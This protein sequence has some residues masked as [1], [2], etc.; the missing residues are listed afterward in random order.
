[1]PLFAVGLNHNSAPLDV[2][3]RMVF[4]GDTL[5][6]S[7][8]DL[9]EQLGV[10]EAVIV[11]TCNRT[12]LYTTLNAVP[13]PQPV[14]EWLCRT[15]GVS[16]DWLMPYLY[17]HQGSHAL[18]HLLRV[19]AGLDSMIL[20]EPQILGQTKAAYAEAAR[21]G[22]LGQV[23]SRA[24]QHA[25]AVAKQIRT[26]TA[27]GANP[28]SVAFAAVSLARQIFGELSQSDALLIGAGE[29]IE[30]TARHLRQAGIR[31]IT[32]ANRTLERAQ[33]LAL[34]LGA[35]AITLSEIPQA[36]EYS[37]IVIA[38]TASPLP[39]IGKGS[40]ERALKARKRKPVFMVDLAVPRDIE[41]EVGDLNDVYLYTVDDLREVIADN[42]RSRQAAAEQ[43][44]EIIHTQVNQFL[45]WVRS[46]E[47][48]DSI[49]ALR[50]RAAGQRDEILARA[51]R[52]LRAGAP[53]EEVLE[54]LANTLTNTLLH[55][56]TAGLREVAASGD[57]RRLSL[58]R[59]LLDLSDEEETTP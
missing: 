15:R 4:S 39:I 32:V 25:F 14:I 36:L 58:A 49:Q 3:E 46:L 55:A 54:Y 22:T 53:P 7:L 48:V 27:I 20:G 23:L 6:S 56:P 11:S 31:G 17:R 35:R 16:S 21:A 41:A 28:V 1:M 42:L 5:Q 59:Q 2:R 8:R 44:E 18:S 38:S 13:D 45:G 37:D 9:K 33:A 30:L 50:N 24:F 51:K 29:T 47:A 12:E 19:S 57:E 52:R 40:V 26:Q 43:A 34:P 10:D